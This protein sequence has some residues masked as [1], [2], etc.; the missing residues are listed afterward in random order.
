MDIKRNQIYETDCM[1]I[2]KRLSDSSIDLIIADP[3]YFRMKGEFDFVFQ[4]IPEYL[5]WCRGWVEECYR[6]LKPTGAFYCWGSCQTIDKLSVLVLDRFDWIKR[7]LIVWNFSTGR[8]GKASYRYESE[9]LWFYS[10]PLHEIN[11]DNI[12]IPYHAGGEK[13]KR[14]NPK[15]KTCGNV[16]ECPRIMPN[17]REATKHPTQKPEKLSERI[18]LASSSPGDLVLIPF[19]GSGT[20]I[21][22][23]M[24]KKRDFIAAE[25]NPAYVR[26]IIL[27]R[28]ETVKKEGFFE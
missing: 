3:P 21:V 24:K 5:E 10:N 27:P 11:Q 4:T 25:I 19:A 9:F 15:G 14:K 7:N 8:P 28:L 20:E 6:V 12:R 26:E 1:E 13:D 2:L 18:L 17:Y 22:S 16:W 23:C